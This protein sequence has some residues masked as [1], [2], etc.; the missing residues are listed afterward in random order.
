MAERYWAAIDE[1]GAVLAQFIN[2]QN[3]ALANDIAGFWRCQRFEV[4]WEAPGP[5]DYV[6]TCWTESGRHPVKEGEPRFDWREIGGISEW[7]AGGDLVSVD[8]LEPPEPLAGM[9]RIIETKQQ[10][11][12]GE[13]LD[14]AGQIVPVI[15]VY[16]AQAKA[17][18][19]ARAR[20]AID[21]LRTPGFDASYAQKRLEVDYWSRG[22]AMTRENYPVSMGEAADRLMP[23]LAVIASYRDAIAREQDVLHAVEPWRSAAKARVADATDPATI[24]QLLAD[25]LAAFPEV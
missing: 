17:A 7:K 2:S 9:P 5:G 13:A 20:E 25:A 16:R 12:G 8:G 19:D 6:H 1:N 15:E 22:R 14:E 24:A 11:G 23:W 3:P 21:A 18:I 4:F 10:L